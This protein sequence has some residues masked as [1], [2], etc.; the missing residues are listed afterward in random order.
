M[1]LC[2]VLVALTGSVA[3][4][5]EWYKPETP[6]RG[7]TSSPD[8]IRTARQMSLS[9]GGQSSA[10]NASQGYLDSLERFYDSPG[11]AAAS[12]QGYRYCHELDRIP[13]P[14]QEL[15]DVLENFTDEC[16]PDNILSL[17]E[18]SY[19]ENKNK[20]PSNPGQIALVLQTIEDVVGKDSEA[21]TFVCRNIPPMLTS[22]VKLNLDCSDR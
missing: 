6:P 2:G 5:G 7:S 11:F 21:Y 20:L 16:T 10:S 9:P 4:S 8:L 18:A 1:F 12:S 17:T 13:A 15:I 22:I 19:K 14:W 3:A